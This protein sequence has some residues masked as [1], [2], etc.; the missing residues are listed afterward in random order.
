MRAVRVIQHREAAPV[1]LTKVHREGSPL[2]CY[3][4]YY[5]TN[6]LKLL[7]QHN[8]VNLTLKTNK[9][10]IKAVLAGDRGI[11]GGINIVPRTPFSLILIF[12]MP[13]A[14]YH[15]S[16]STEA[17]TGW[18]LKPSCPL[19]TEMLTNMGM[20]TFIFLSLSRER[21]S[22]H[23]NNS[24]GLGYKKKKCT[25]FQYQDFVFHDIKKIIW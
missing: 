15:L 3:M 12:W 16:V 11:P 14:M 10:Q 22:V 13:G 6:L 21:H 4:H 25:L 9:S 19:W 2:I 20:L 7:S 18:S 24:L 17:R 1:Q 5:Q 23:S 8:R